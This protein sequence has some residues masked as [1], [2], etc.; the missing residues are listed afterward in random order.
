MALKRVGALWNKTDKTGKD[1]M[2]G[3]LELGALGE[4]KIMVFPNEKREENHP[5]GPSSS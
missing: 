2:S 1:Y 3:T 4:A 5:T